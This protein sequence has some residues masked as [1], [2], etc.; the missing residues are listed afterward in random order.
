MKRYTSNEDLQFIESEQTFINDLHFSPNSQS[1][2]KKEMAVNME[3]VDEYI[4]HLLR[5]KLFSP[6]QRR[7][8]KLISKGFQ[9]YSIQQFRTLI[10][11]HSSQI[12]QIT[13]LLTE[14]KDWFMESKLT[15]MELKLLLNGQSYMHSTLLLNEMDMSRLSS[16]I[17]ENFEKVVCNLNVHQI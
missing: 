15:V 10:L 8:L 1:I 7:K 12:P 17:R 3:H 16:Q 4:I 11:N 6:I 13:E 5:E 14:N 2:D 9:W